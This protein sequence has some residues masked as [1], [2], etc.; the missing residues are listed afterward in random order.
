[1]VVGI[2]DLDRAHLNIVP[3]GTVR[4]GAGFCRSIV[5][6]SPEAPDQDILSPATVVPIAHTGAFL[7]AGEAASLLI[8]IA[9]VVD[10]A[11]SALREPRCRFQLMERPVPG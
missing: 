6:R 9:K 7:A 5:G 3:V 2:L 4:T 10:A 8:C 1:M 11:H